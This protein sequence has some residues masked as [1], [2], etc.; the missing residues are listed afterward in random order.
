MKQKRL[1]NEKV[2]S[3]VQ[4]SYGRILA[5]LAARTRDLAASEDALAEAFQI[6]IVEWSAKGVPTN[7]EGWL[8]KVAKNRIFNQLKHTRVVERSTDF[9]LEMS[10]ESTEAQLQKEFD[11]YDDDRLKM[12]FVCAHPSIDENDRTPLMLQ[13]VLGLDVETIASVFLVSPAAMAKRLVRAKEKIRV[14]GVPFEIPDASESESRLEDVLSAIYAIYGS[15]WNQGFDFDSQSDDL[16]HEAEFLT[17]LVIK[18]LPDAPE[19]KAL[20]ALMYYCEARKN[21]RRSKNGKF[22][23][24]QDQDPN[25]WSTE[26]IQKAEALLNTASKKRTFGRFQLEAAIQSAHCTRRLKN[27]ENWEHILILYQGLMERFPSLGANVNY[28]LALAKVKGP[29]AGLACLDLIAASE[30]KIYQPY[31]VARATLLEST[32]SIENAKLALQLAIGITFDSAAR[33]YLIEKLNSMP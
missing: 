6:A 27:E 9:L 1:A 25:M 8:F 24:L 14:T 33:A 3:L 7:P 2:T 21:A 15:S 13:V 19:P 32:G 23:P 30:V 10:Q 29:A 5:H 17:S 11:D 18:S 31:W 4:E 16:Y 20:L 26:L 12:L 22:I 28:C